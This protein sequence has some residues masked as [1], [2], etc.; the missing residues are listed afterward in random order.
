MGLPVV[1]GLGYRQRLILQLLREAARPLPSGYLTRACGI[2]KPL[3][4]PP[5]TASTTYMALRALRQRGLVESVA[6]G[7]WRA[8]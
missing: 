4:W 3:P 1:K 5:A 2:A 7:Y 6:H 8:V